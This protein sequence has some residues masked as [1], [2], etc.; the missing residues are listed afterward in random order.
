MRIVLHNWTPFLRAERLR[1]TKSLRRQLQDN[2]RIMREHKPLHIVVF[3]LSLTS[4]WGNG[5]ATTYRALLRGLAQLGHDVLFLE[6][7][8]P[9]YAQNRDLPVCDY[10]R[11]VLYS[12]F[13]EVRAKYANAVRQADLVMVGSYVMD[14]VELG[15]WVTRI[16]RGVTAFYDIDT[17]VTLARMP[18]N[19]NNYISRELVSR[20]E[21]YLSFAGGAVLQCL[22]RRYGARRARAL[23]CSVDPELYA[24]RPTEARWDLGYMGTYSE[25]RQPYVDELLIEAARRWKAGKFVVAGPQYPRTVIWPRNMK[26]ITHV[27]PAKHA[28]F[29][30]SQRFTLN[31]TRREMRAQGYSPSVRLFEAAACGVAIISDNWPGLD[32]IFAPDSEILITESCTDTLFY[33]QDV[34]ESQR[35]EI[36]SKARVRVLR[37][38]TGIKRAGELLAYYY[39]VSRTAAPV[40]DPIAEDAQREL[41]RSSASNAAGG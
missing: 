29:Y 16:A 13:A 27:S 34:G 38:H 28:E 26:H 19:D 6:R 36:A 3:G 30:A 2:E 41:A 37:E 1:G 20:Y 17:P 21:L 33:L 22:E 14:G 4:S 23:Y 35:E 8:Q 24:P 25:D 31:V 18:S 39:E 11:V 5:H 40:T 7:D 15:Q 12:N 9:W 32:S 10:A